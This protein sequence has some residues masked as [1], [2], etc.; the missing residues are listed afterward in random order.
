MYLYVANQKYSQQSSINKC[1]VLYQ[2]L[3]VARKVLQYRNDVTFLAIGKGPQLD[4][5]M[6]MLSDQEKENIRF[7]GFRNDTDELLM[8]TDISI[9]CTNFR[10]H[11][12]GISN[13]ILESMYL[14]KPVI[15]T[16]GGG[17]PEIITDGIDGYLIHENKVSEFVSKLELLLNNSNIYNELSHAAISKVEEKF[18]LEKSVNAYINLY[19]S[20]C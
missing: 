18:S 1:L 10:Y 5:Y 17:T 13:V 6:R 3:K 14:G 4:Y 9:L 16:Y 12:E 20:L 11:Q 8:I 2:N 15:A 19:K 7:L